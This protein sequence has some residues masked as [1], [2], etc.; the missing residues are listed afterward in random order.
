MITLA[1]FIAIMVEVDQKN[2]TRMNSVVS[3]IVKINGC[4]NKGGICGFQENLI[5]LILEHVYLEFL[6]GDVSNHFRVA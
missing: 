6:L 1:I 3:S 4:W 2:R 5:N